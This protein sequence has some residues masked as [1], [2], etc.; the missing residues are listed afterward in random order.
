MKSNMAQAAYPEH[1]KD[2]EL[3]FSLQSNNKHF[4][5]NYGD[6][7]A[8]YDIPSITMQWETFKTYLLKNSGR[9]F[10]TPSSSIPST[11]TPSTSPSSNPSPSPLQLLSN[12]IHIR[13][14]S[15][16]G[17]ELPINTQEEFQYALYTFRERARAGEVNHL[18]LTRTLVNAIHPTPLTV[19]TTAVVKANGQQRFNFT[20]LPSSEDSKLQGLVGNNKMSALKG[21]DSL[22]D[23]ILECDTDDNGV[24]EAANM[25]RRSDLAIGGD[26]LS[27][28]DG[29]ELEE[30]AP[31]W[32]S[33]YMTKFKQELI[34]EITK[35]NTTQ[36]SSNLKKMQTAN[37]VV[38]PKRRQ[39]KSEHYK[40]RPKM[41]Y[42]NNIAALEN[43]S[44]DNTDINTIATTPIITNPQK[45]SPSTSKGNDAQQKPEN[46]T[47]QI[48]LKAKRLVGSSTN[49]RGSSD[50]D[51]L[52]VIKSNHN[53]SVKQ[54]PQ[55]TKKDSC[56]KRND[57]N[58]T[59]DG[60]DVQNKPQWGT[61]PEDACL[62]SRRIQG[63]FIEPSRM[64]KS[65]Y[66]Y[67]CVLPP[68]GNHGH[69]VDSK[70]MRE[71]HNV[72]N[73]DGD[74]RAVV[75][76]EERMVTKGLG[77]QQWTLENTGTKPWDSETEL[78][79]CWGSVVPINAKITCPPLIP[80]EHGNVAFYYTIP[81]N[82]GAYEGYCHLYHHDQRF[83]PWLGFK[84][85]VTPP[86]Q[87]HNSQRTTIT[88]I[89]P[90][91]QLYS[92]NCHKT[93]H[94]P[95]NMSMSAM[96]ANHSNQPLTTTTTTTQGHHESFTS[97]S[98]CPSNSYQTAPGTTS[99][100]VEG[101]DDKKWDDVIA[102]IQGVVVRDGG[103]VCDEGVKEEGDRA[104]LPNS[105]FKRFKGN[106]Q[107]STDEH[108]PEY[109]I[110]APDQH[111][112]YVTEHQKQ[113]QVTKQFQ[114]TD[115]DDDEDD[116][117]DDDDNDY[118]AADDLNV[119]KD[120]VI[121][122]KQLQDN[123]D[124]ENASII[125][126]AESIHSFPATNISVA[127]SCTSGNGSASGSE[128][129]VVIPMPKRTSDSLTLSDCY[130][131]N[132]D[133]CP[134]LEPDPDCCTN[135][136]G[137]SVARED[138]STLDVVEKSDERLN[139]ETKDS[140]LEE[141]S[142]AALAIALKNIEDKLMKEQEEQSLATTNNI[143]NIV[144]TIA[145]EPV[146]IIDK[147]NDNKVVGSDKPKEFVEVTDS[148]YVRGFDRSLE[149]LQTC[150]VDL[151]TN[152]ARLNSVSEFGP[153][154]S[155]QK[156]T[157]NKQHCAATLC[158][159][160]TNIIR[161]NKLENTKNRLFVFPEDSPGFEIFPPVNKTPKPNS[162]CTQTQTTASNL[163]KKM[164]AQ[165]DSPILP[166]NSFDTSQN[167]LKPDVIIQKQNNTE[168]PAGIWTVQNPTKFQNVSHSTPNTSTSFDLQNNPHSCPNH[169][170][171]TQR[172]SYHSPC[173]FK[174][175]LNLKKLGKD[176]FYDSSS[177]NDSSSF[178]CPSC[179]CDGLCWRYQGKTE[180]DYRLCKQAK[181]TSADEIRL[182]MRNLF[183]QLAELEPMKDPYLGDKESDSSCKKN[184]VESVLRCDDPPT[185]S[186]EFKAKV[187]LLQESSSERA[188]M[189]LFMQRQL[190]EYKRKQASK[191]LRFVKS[192]DKA[193]NVSGDT[194]KIEIDGKVTEA[195]S[196]RGEALGDLFQTRLRLGDIDEPMPDVPNSNANA[197]VSVKIE[198]QQEP[199]K[200][201]PSSSSSL[202]TG[203][204][205]KTHLFQEHFELEQSSSD[206]EL[207]NV[208]LQGGF[209]SATAPVEN[210]TQRAETVEEDNC[211]ISYGMKQQRL[212]Q[213]HCDGD[214]VLGDNMRALIDMGFN[215]FYA[216]LELLKSNENNIIL[217]LEK[218]LPNF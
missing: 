91:P 210:D 214:T 166:P 143:M 203:C 153:Q 135:E 159:L 192:V 21:N 43:T 196:S 73:G 155:N 6:I 17:V 163:I 117:D 177:S 71:N 188:K 120:A 75:L 205:Y 3:V 14:I 19:H 149:E 26:N 154:K 114:L 112:R 131:E 160:C 48:K 56:Y 186:S 199:V 70:K 57:N 176:T 9:Y 36:M 125:S 93:E 107:L 146:V 158:D 195:C 5:K 212:I 8:V 194:V 28:S 38:C 7:V 110:N 90:P 10:D 157:E 104:I 218:L 185:V 42:S 100:K 136:Q 180:S 58:L 182:Q 119:G 92:T 197:S 118:Y 53:F 40:R 67:K 80:G 55:Q 189:P 41:S 64:Q 161:K 103:L 213:L 99:I 62:E 12:D 122:D 123:S 164:T 175:S 109:F 52:T 85:T 76:G 165:P 106:E 198:D 2:L 200:D 172:K 86:E 121:I 133:S 173:T 193:V 16:S 183:V 23:G 63:D 145:T 211:D 1:R 44:C 132:E 140:I 169:P 20:I 11:S 170:Q 167:I 208:A 49:L 105:T 39:N 191:R 115:S 142:L 79:F 24:D 168:L 147:V 65:R 108:D 174:S 204:P 4:F 13:Y 51:T 130:I 206:E 50:S 46:I 66:F 139:V 54:Q 152:S 74:L 37:H 187:P 32:F 202:Y 47:K 87:L 151:S 72:E 78:R 59:C 128:E 30:K 97:T 209:E 178:V 89:L 148:G 171:E 29:K 83:G 34:Q 129:F 144:E 216:N 45:I 94:S 95:P 126:I 61:D 217:V 81:V 96:L 137:G 98:A 88:S 15:T 31:E 113:Q 162:D 184:K 201:V 25:R 156:Q 68:R 134:E 27:M 141:Q 138:N 101:L 124:S 60:F 111:M 82:A 102:V 18:K 33:K 179:Q 69:S 84:I 150:P 181:A 35:V 22:V 207:I 116:S 77:K 215:N 190:E 127:G